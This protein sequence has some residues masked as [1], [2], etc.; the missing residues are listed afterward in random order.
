MYYM[1]VDDKLIEKGYTDEYIVVEVSE[2]KK[3]LK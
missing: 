3:L 2:W 1:F